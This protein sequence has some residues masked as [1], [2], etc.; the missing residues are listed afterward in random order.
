M[1]WSKNSFAH[2]R[3]FLEELVSFDKV[4]VVFVH[5]ANVDVETRSEQR[6]FPVHLQ[7]DVHSLVVQLQQHHLARTIS[8]ATE[9]GLELLGQGRIER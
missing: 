9:V 8:F 2:C 1:I 3:P 7:A 5:N 4:F 6:L